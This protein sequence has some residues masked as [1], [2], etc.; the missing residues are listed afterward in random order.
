MNVLN[1]TVCWLLVPSN[2]STFLLLLHSL[3][4]D[5]KNEFWVLNEKEFNALIKGE[6][7]T[8]LEEL[9]FGEQFPELADDEEEFSEFMEIA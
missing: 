4:A 5:L 9:R 1:V 7:F 8:E 3:E 6:E 2:A